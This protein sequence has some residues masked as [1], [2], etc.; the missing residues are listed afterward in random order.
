MRSL[1]V[2]AVLLL[3]QTLF[4]Q[5]ELQIKPMTVVVG[6][7]SPEIFGTQ[8]LAGE[9][10]KP[11]TQSAVLITATGPY[12][13]IEVEAETKPAFDLADLIRAPGR[14]EW[15]LIGSGK[16]RISAYAYD[17][18][19]GQSRKRI[20]IE[21]GPPKPPEPPA[22]DPP[23]PA[24]ELPIEGVGL[25]VLVV[26]ESSELSRL[27]ETQKQVLSSTIVREF[28]NSHCAKDGDTYEYRFYDQNADMTFANDRWKKA[29]AK[30]RKSVPWVAISNGRKG[31]SG[32][33]PLSIEEMLALLK[34]YAETSNSEFGL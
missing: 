29:M 32:P 1:S 14:P 16:F 12:K 22:P 24:D 15:L 11:S 13:S 17:P 9:K 21:L 23:T 8:L 7:E 10:S 5:I 6:I 34:K 3:S 27:P 33:L 4:G 30:A 18:E 26:Y 31:Y 28:L 20:D 2:L 25:R 19:R